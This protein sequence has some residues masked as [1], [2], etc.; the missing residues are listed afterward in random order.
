M[1]SL[2]SSCSL[3]HLIANLHS[4]LGQMLSQRLGRDSCHCSHLFGYLPGWT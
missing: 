2:F 4:L 3:L 1:L